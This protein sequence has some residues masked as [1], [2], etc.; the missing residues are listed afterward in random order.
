MTM[1]P[2]DAFRAETRPVPSW[3]MGRPMFEPGETLHVGVIDVGSNS[4]R[5]VV[6]DG[7]ARSPAYFYNEKI[8][9]ALG[10]GL[11]DTGRLN[12]RGRDRALDALC[13]FAALARGMGLRTMMAVATAAVREAEDGPAFVQEVE[14]RTGLRLEVIPGDEEARLSAQGVTLGW[15]GAY[16]LVVDIGGSSMDLGDLG[17]GRVGRPVD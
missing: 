2:D 4:V 14:R 15:P 17:Q 11:S 3:D 12:S 16:G 13:R 6:F 9:C 7:A 5:F 10:A 1:A 8:M